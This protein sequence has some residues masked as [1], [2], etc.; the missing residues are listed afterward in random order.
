SQRLAR[1]TCSVFRIHPKSDLHSGVRNI[2]LSLRLRLLGATCAD[3]PISSGGKSIANRRLSQQRGHPNLLC[4]IL[5]PLPVTNGG[6]QYQTS[7][8]ARALGAACLPHGM[9]L[10]DTVRKARFRLWI[11]ISGFESLGGSQRITGQLAYLH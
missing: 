1:S 9:I 10:S 11:S 5:C 6:T 4:P 8:Q 7:S 3:S 2:E